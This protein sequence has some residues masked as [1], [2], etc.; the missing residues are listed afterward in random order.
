MDYSGQ[1][2]VGESGDS[3]AGSAAARRRPGPA[4]P[5]AEEILNHT[6]DC[7][8]L[9]D[10][11]WRFTYLNRRAE[12]VLGRGETL[13]D[14]A[15]HHVFA[16]EQGSAEWKQMQRAAERREYAS[17]EF[18]ASHLRLWF[19][20]HIHPID[21]G[22]Q[23]YFR[24]V[25]PRREAEAALAQREAALRLAMEAVGDAAWDWDLPTGRLSIAGRQVAALGY[26]T[27]RADASA[28]AL[29]AIIHPDDLEK[30]L[31]ELRRHLAGRSKF[32]SGKF[33]VRSTDGS[34]HRTVTRGRVIERDPVTNWA[35]RM[36]GTSMDLARLVRGV[37][38]P[39][40]S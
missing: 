40:R 24:D 39:A 11:R 25:T 38:R 31:Q 3:P 15:L 19:E 7:V 2:N 26:G 12:Q 27:L 28:A 23:V 29:G 10:E 17:F 37:K 4:L 1:G 16:A 33:R 36:V 20:V 14:R 34:W 21:D 9:L 8:V 32:F 13:I 30:T 35:V 22:L 5:C 18:F 6:T